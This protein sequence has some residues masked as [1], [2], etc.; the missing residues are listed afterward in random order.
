MQRH[1]DDKRIPALFENRG[2]KELMNG[3]VEFIRNSLVFEESHSYA[4]DYCHKALVCLDALP[5]NESR[6]SLKQLVDYVLMRQA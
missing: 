3:A 4:E 1:P 6:D 2:D 5:D